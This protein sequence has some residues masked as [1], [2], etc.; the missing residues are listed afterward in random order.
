MT[1]ASCPTSTAPTS[2]KRRDLEAAQTLFIVSSKTF[3]TL[4]TMTNANTAR[5][6]LLQRMGGD[7][8]RREALRGGFHQRKVR[9]FGIDTA[10]MFE[11]WDWVGGRCS[12]CS[13]IGLST[14][15]AIGPEHFR[16]C[17][18]VSRDGRALPYRP[19]RAE[20]PVLMGLLAVWYCFFG[21]GSI[22]VLPDQY[23]KHVPPTSSS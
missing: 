16:A 2:P 20:P 14:M 6:W 15:L 13:A 23:L 11:F 8:R 21:A 5:Q 4:E 22:A 3:T 10:N 18:T 12:M 7:A 1:S 17:S 19:V 9:E